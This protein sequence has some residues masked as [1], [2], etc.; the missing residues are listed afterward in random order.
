MYEKNNIEDLVQKINK[1]ENK[2]LLLKVSNQNKL[3]IDGML[4][5]KTYIK[6]LEKIIRK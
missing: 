4:E 6:N 1:L 5:E 2:K 3:F